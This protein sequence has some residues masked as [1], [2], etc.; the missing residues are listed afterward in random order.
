MEET[1]RKKAL[2]GLVVLLVLLGIYSGFLTQVPTERTDQLSAFIDHHDS[3]LDYLNESALMDLFYDPYFLENYSVS[4]QS[5]YGLLEIIPKSNPD[6]EITLYRDGNDVSLIASGYI[7][8]NA[9]STD[10][11]YGTLETETRLE[12]EKVLDY[13]GHPELKRMIAVDDND[14]AEIDLMFRQAIF[15]GLLALLLIYFFLVSFK[16]GFLFINNK[17]VTANERVFVGLGMMYLSIVLGLLNIWNMLS[18]GVFYTGCAVC[19]VIL[20]ILFILGF[21]LILKE[22]KIVGQ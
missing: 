4:N 8:I 22:M 16:D 7:N 9:L 21:F 5:Q 1:F 17:W 13:M 19:L 18:I 3:Y 6:I 12:L 14:F 15:F 11:D 20:A 10:K 2:A